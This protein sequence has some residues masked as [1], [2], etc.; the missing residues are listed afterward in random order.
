MASGSSN[1]NNNGGKKGAD[2]SMAAVH[3]LPARFR[4]SLIDE[5]EIAMIAVRG[6]HGGKKA[7]VLHTL[8]CHSHPRSPTALPSFSS[9]ERRPKATCE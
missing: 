8:R 3:E 7:V 4:P 9:V 2:S 6:S 5:D 1:N